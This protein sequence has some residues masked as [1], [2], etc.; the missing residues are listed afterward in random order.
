LGIPRPRRRGRGR[1]RTARLRIL[2]LLQPLLRQPGLA[3]GLLAL[4]ADLLQFPGDALLLGFAGLLLGQP[5]L[6]LGFFLALALGQV[7]LLLAAR[8]AAALQA[9]ILR[10]WTRPES[11]PLGQRC[12]IVIR[13]AVGGIVVDAKVDPSCPYDELGRRSVEAAVLKAEPL[14]YAGFESVFNRTLILNF[15]AQDQ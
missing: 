6:P 2:D 12:K 3:L 9:A 5:L 15:E 14:P 10:N 8:Y 4:G 11:V 13:Q 7:D 1:G